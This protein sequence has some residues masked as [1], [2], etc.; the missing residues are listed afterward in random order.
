MTQRYWKATDEQ[1]VHGNKTSAILLDANGLYSEIQRMRLPV[2]DYRKVPPDEAAKIDWMLGT[3]ADDEVGYILSVDLSFPPHLHALFNFF[4]PAP[5]KKTVTWDMLSKC[6]K[7][8]HR[9]LH[10]DRKYVGAAKLVTTLHKRERYVVHS[11]SLRAYLRL[12]L[13]LERVHVCYSFRQEA[14]MRPFIDLCV[15]KRSAARNKFEKNL[16]KYVIIMFLF[17]REPKQLHMLARLLFSLFST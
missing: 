17:W 5:E 4:C 2:G 10:G 13:I 14:F 12:G 6:A 1:D 8:Y 16:Y 9:T 11:N 3:D 15:A 7:R